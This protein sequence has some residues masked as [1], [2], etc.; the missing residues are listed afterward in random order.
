MEVEP[1]A[2]ARAVTAPS[3]SRVNEANTA[4]AL[5]D[6]QDNTDPVIVAVAT[7]ATSTIRPHYDAINLVEVAKEVDAANK[8]E[9]KNNSVDN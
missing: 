6:S 4:A 5:T 3:D 2:M 8:V 7:T 1:V 9:S